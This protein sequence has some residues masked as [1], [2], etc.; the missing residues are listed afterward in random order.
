M[1]TCFFF[2]GNEVICTGVAGPYADF[3]EVSLKTFFLYGRM[4]SRRLYFYIVK[5]KSSAGYMSW[6]VDGKDVL[7]THDGQ[8]ILGY[9]QIDG[10]VNGPPSTAPTSS[11]GTT[12]VIGVIDMASKTCGGFFA[13]NTAISAADITAC[14]ESL[15]CILHY[16]TP[17]N[18]IIL[19]SIFQPTKFPSSGVFI[20]MLERLL[21]LLLLLPSIHSSNLSLLPSTLSPTEWSVSACSTGRQP[22]RARR[23]YGIM[24]TPSTPMHIP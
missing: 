13:S 1:R 12:G 17:F 14:S 3:I 20:S 19:Y 5:D 15:C 21:S 22:A 18:K 4:S 6:N 24:Y 16:N 23:R 8:N 9:V 7:T 2:T 10:L 11:V